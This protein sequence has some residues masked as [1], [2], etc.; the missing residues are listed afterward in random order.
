[1]ASHSLL[2]GLRPTSRSLSY[3]PVFVVGTA[4][5]KR[6]RI[7]ANDWNAD[8]RPPSLPE[9]DTKNKAIQPQLNR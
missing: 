5:H 9:A 1:M 7:L 3:F 6:L 8:M 2:P 4:E